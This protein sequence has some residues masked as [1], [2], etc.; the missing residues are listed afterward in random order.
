MCME[1]RLGQGGQVGDTPE[2]GRKR[3]KWRLNSEKRE[4]IDKL[5]R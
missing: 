2:R 3:P 5:G 1:V 4:S